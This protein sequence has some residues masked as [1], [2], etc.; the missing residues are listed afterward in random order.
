M[1]FYSQGGSVALSSMGATDQAL[2]QRVS[3]HRSLITYKGQY[4]GKVPRP[5][6]NSGQGKL[7]ET[8]CPKPLTQ[9]A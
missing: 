8:C 1:T 7:S 9:S 4:S 5:Q 6:N 2:L 3:V